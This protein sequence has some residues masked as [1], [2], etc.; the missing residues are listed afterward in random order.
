MQQIGLDWVYHHDE[1][2]TDASDETRNSPPPPL[3]S[4]YRTVYGHWPNGWPP[5]AKD[6]L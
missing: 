2:H 5:W 3:I 1:D 4:A 6:G